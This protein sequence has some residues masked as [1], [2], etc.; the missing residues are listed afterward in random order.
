MS[1]SLSQIVIYRAATA[2]QLEI[3][4]MYQNIPTKYYKNHNMYYNNRNLYHK[5]EMF[6]RCISSAQHL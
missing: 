2:S 4:T 6:L 1:Q 3:Y 5:K